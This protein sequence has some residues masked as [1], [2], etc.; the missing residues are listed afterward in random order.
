MVLTS[1]L[2][3]A[4][5]TPDVPEPAQGVRLSWVRDT[6]ATHCITAQEM[7]RDVRARLGRDP[8]RGEARQWIEGFVSVKDGRTVVQLFERDAQGNTVGSRVLSDEAG[9]CHNLDDAVSLA[10]ALLIDPSARLGPLDASRSAP[11][12]PSPTEA[13]DVKR[14][15][16]APESAVREEPEPRSTPSPPPC[17]SKPSQRGTPAFSHGSLSLSPLVVAN[18]FPKTTWGLELVGQASVLADD[19][20]L[21]VG[22]LYLPEQSVEHGAGELGYGLS[23]VDLGAQG[24]LGDEPLRWMGGLSLQAGALHT[25]VRQPDPLEPGDRLW[26][27]GRAQL[28]AALQLWPPLWL[29]ARVFGE[30][31]FTRW[32]FRVRVDDVPTQAYRQPWFL[33]GAAL[34]LLWHF[35]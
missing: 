35:G 17:V 15:G 22:M 2:C 26:L 34:G 32:R 13:A 20:F 6:E 28:G 7:E 23:A 11:S 31:P 12:N 27:A 33:P 16:I 8:F 19:L 29:H 10:V 1:S 18:V 3:G 30:V 24:W 21:A 5:P 9:D 14:Q 25:V 4:Q